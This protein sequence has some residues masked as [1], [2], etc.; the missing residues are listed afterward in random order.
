MKVGIAGTGAIAMGYAA[1]LMKN[2]HAVQVWSPSGRGAAGLSAGVPVTITG[3]IDGDFLPG[4]CKNKAELT[5]SDVIILAL[6]AYGHRMVIDSIAPHIKPRHT[7][8][9]SGHLSF[10]ALFLAKKL[11]ARG[12]EIPVVGWSTTVLTSK[13]QAP[14][15]ARIGAIRSKIDMATVPARFGDHA[16]T[17]CVELFGDRFVVKDDLLTIA[18]S[19]LNPQN[20]LAIALSN[21][22]RIEH[23]ETW[24]QNSNITPGVGQLI[25]ALDRERVELAET[26]GKHVRTI[27]EHY[28]MSYGVEEASVAEASARLVGKGSDPAGPKTIA[29]R[30]ILEDVPFGLVPTLLLA[31]MAG[32][33]MPLHQ[34]G[35]D[36]IGACYGRSFRADNDL[37]PELELAQINALRKSVTVGYLPAPLACRPQ[38]P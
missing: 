9:I 25:E 8:I 33:D 30:Y 7:V 28:K 22:T 13:T 23:G 21:L 29:T 12:I 24:G 38:L 18:L 36:I 31:E 37:L 4:A 15:T 1:F 14:N 16:H 27:S 6:P 11:A 26:L 17:I 32:V 19:N 20:H 3:A 5:D 10:A 35:V 34:G 2:G